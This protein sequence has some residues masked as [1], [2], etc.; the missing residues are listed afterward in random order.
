MFDNEQ[1]R[2]HVDEGWLIYMPNCPHDTPVTPYWMQFIFAAVVSENII[3]KDDD[4]ETRQFILLNEDM[5]IIA[6]NIKEPVND[7]G[8]PVEDVIQFAK[9]H[10]DE[11]TVHDLVEYCSSI[12]ST[13]NLNNEMSQQDFVKILTS[14]MSEEE[15]GEAFEG[16]DN[17]F[18]LGSDEDEDE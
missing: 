18:F 15:M 2:V 12:R 14:D 4:P 5:E 8:A 7:D 10:L 9:E 3:W 16:Y 11:E 6:V 13:F 1:D 17:V